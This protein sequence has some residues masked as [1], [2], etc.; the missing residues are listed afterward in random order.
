[1]ESIETIATEIYGA[2]GISLSKR[3]Q[4]S[5]E[6][7]ISWG[8]GAVPVCMAKTQY[9][10][11]HD[12]GLLGAPEGFIL[13]IEDIRLNA[14]AGF[15]VVLCGSIMTMPG[16]GKRPAASDMDLDPSGNITGAFS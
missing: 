9:S 14:G 3:A 7:I 11:S 8:H 2:K 15:A 4:K 12:P 5:L 13:P 16:L 1:M 6:R 10:F